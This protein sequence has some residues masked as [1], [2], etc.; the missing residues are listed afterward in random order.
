MDYY[1][2]GAMLGGYQKYTPKPSNIA[3]LSIY[4]M[5]CHR[6]SL[7]RQSCAFQRLRSCVAAAS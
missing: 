7:I 3:L 2:W 4:G 5:I 6:S 1:V